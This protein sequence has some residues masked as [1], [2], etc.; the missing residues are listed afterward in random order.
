[1]CE[2]E[3]QRQSALFVVRFKGANTDNFNAEWDSVVPDLQYPINQSSPL[4][5]ITPPGFAPGAGAQPCK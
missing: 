5:T 4:L 1:M 3:S 2:L